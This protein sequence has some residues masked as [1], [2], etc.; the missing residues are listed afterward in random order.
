MLVVTFAVEGRGNAVEVEGQ[1]FVY[2]RTDR[3]SFVLPARCAHRGG[4]LNLA[5]VEEHPDGRGPRLVCPWHDQGGPLG[6]HLARGIPAVRRGDSVTA[7]L[8]VPAGSPYRLGHR[9]V[10]PGL[11]RCTPSVTAS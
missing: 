7:V 1:G 11:R 4:P 10:S 3:G 8:P 2:A 5:R 6:R 9:P